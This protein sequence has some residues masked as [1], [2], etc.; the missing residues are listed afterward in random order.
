MVFSRTGSERLR[1]RSARPPTSARWW[2]RISPGHAR[3]RALDA[4]GRVA[5]R[6][7]SV[8]RITKQAVRLGMGRHFEPWDAEIH[9]TQEAEAMK[10]EMPDGFKD[11]SF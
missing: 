3:A 1:A 5:P 6:L 9:A 2:Q 8:A 7:R 10:G 4:S 11:F